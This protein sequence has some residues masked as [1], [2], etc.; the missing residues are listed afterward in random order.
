MKRKLLLSKEHPDQK[1]LNRKVIMSESKRA[2][3]GRKQ[4]ETLFQNKDFV[5]RLF[6]SPATER[7][8]L[9]MAEAHRCGMD[10][11]VTDSRGRSKELTEKDLDSVVGGIALV[12]TFTFGHTLY[13]ARIGPDGFSVKGIASV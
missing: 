11:T 10:I 6:E 7:D 8:N 1:I 3:D 13:E 9:L 4:I 5:R 12:T 2:T